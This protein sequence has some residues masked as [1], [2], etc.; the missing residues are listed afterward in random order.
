M[1]PRDEALW[2]IFIVFC[3]AAVG[4]VY[5]FVVIERASGWAAIFVVFAVFYMMFRFFRF[6]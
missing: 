6:S 1:R 2:K 3:I 4:I 5:Y